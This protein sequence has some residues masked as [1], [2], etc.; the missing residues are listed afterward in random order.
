VSVE[1]PDLEQIILEDPA[2]VAAAALVEPYR[3]RP[4]LK[5]MRIRSKPVGAGSGRYYYFSRCLST[6]LKCVRCVQCTYYLSFPLQ[7]CVVLFPP[8]WMPMLNRADAWM[9]VKWWSAGLGVPC[10]M[11]CERRCCV[12]ESAIASGVATTRCSPLHLCP[13]LDIA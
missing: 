11:A 5:G 2:P 9:I 12:S 13:T 6:Y 8:Q 4:Q 7:R 1:T 10:V 3:G